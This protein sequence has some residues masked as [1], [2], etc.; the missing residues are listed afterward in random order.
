LIVSRLEGAE[1]AAF[2]PDQYLMQM[3][4][5]GLNTYGYVRVQISPKDYEAAT[6][7]LLE[8]GQDA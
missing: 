8:P 6:K 5:W 7:F 3:I 2:I 1:I 4:C